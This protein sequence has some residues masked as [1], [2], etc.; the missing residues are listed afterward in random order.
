[1]YGKY[2]DT[3]VYQHFQ[4]THSRAPYLDHELL[5]IENCAMKESRNANRRALTAQQ[6]LERTK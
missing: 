1:M 2:H 3:R 5:N 4:H 6:G